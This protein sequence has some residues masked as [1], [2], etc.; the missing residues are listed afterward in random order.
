MS[1]SEFK[2][3]DGLK[4]IAGAMKYSTQGLTHMIRHEAAFRQELIACCVLVPL[5]LWLPLGAVEKLLLLGAV[6]LVLITEIINSAIE[7]VV[8]RVSL[9]RHPL[10]GRAKDMGSAAVFLAVIWGAVV[11]LTLAG[12]LVWRLVFPG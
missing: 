4:R 5:A 12:P 11:W 8:D 6:A 7:A 1:E 3:T 9:E 10:A 2:S